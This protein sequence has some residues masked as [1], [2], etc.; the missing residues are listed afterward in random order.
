MAHVTAAALVAENKVLAHPASV[1]TIPTSAG[2]EDHVSMGVLAA[3]KAAVIVGNAETVLAIEMLA[4]SLALDFL[5]PKTAGKGAR[6]AQLFF[7]RS[8]A[9]MMG[10]RFLAPDIEK[11]RAIVLDPAF[12]A[13]VEKASGPLA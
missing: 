1:D 8:V 3:R 13:A 2:K 5:A 11:A 10:D 6:A 4:A 7:R 9:G 12:R